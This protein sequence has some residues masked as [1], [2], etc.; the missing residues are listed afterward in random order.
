MLRTLPR[1]QKIGKKEKAR[2]D[3]APPP[4]KVKRK[5]LQCVYVCVCDLGVARA[6]AHTCFTDDTQALVQAIACIVVE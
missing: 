2:V 6:C 5:G 4:Q 3:I 1:K